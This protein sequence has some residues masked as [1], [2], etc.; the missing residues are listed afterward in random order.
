MASPVRTLL[1]PGPFLAALVVAAPAVAGNGG[2]APVSPESDQAEGIST[3][4]WLVTAFVLFIFVLVEGLLIAFAVRYRRRRRVAHADGPQIHGATRLETMWTAGPVLIVAIIAAFVLVELPD[5]RDVPAA[6][7]AGG[8]PLA[9]QV[10][11]RQYYWQFTYPNGAI[12][13][14]RLRLPVGRAVELDVTAPDWD[15]IH[16][17]WIPALAGKTDAIPGTTNRLRFVPRRTGTFTGQCAE[18]CGLQHAAMLATVEVLPQSEFDSWVDQ[19]AQQVDAA[20]VQPFGEES[21]AAACAK[22][23]GARGEGGV[24]AS[25]PA[26]AGNPIVADEQ[27]L[28][29]VVERGRNEMPSVGRDWSDEQLDALQGYLRE[30]LPGG[31]ES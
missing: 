7:T 28:R 12:A 17:W 3:A 20:A 2:F 23:H 16:S 22:C 26:L 25:A 27:G 8:K 6:S 30:E 18:L 29:A 9:I 10:E 31:G 5:I 13:L 24:A 4:F 19:R 15:V 11:G 21:Y 14:D 1:L